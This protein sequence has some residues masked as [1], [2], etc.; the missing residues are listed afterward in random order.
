MSTEP[1]DDIVRLVSAENSVQAHI[2]EQALQEEG[3]QVQVLGDYL[4]VGFGNLQGV[5]PELWVHRD[6]RRARDGNLERT[7]LRSTRRGT[8]RGDRL[9]SR[10]RVTPGAQTAKARTARQ[11]VR[12]WPL[13]LQGCLPRLA[14]Q[15]HRRL[16]LHHFLQRLERQRLYHRACRLGLDHH[17]LAGRRI[18]T[19]PFFRGRLVHPLDLDQSRQP[20]QAGALLAQFLPEKVPSAHPTPHPL[21]SSSDSTTWPIPAGRLSS[22]V[23]S[24]CCF[25]P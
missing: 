3:I 11:P 7:C 23:P 12:F 25:Q 14:R 1:A 2:W 16:L 22:S 13:F 9:R 15:G 18:A 17:R 24:A 5:T 10:H 4:E 21:A 8:R 20:K 19:H 6:R